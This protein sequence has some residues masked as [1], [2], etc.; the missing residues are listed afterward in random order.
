MERYSRQVLFPFIGEEGQKKL[1]QSTVLVVGVGAL[2]TVASNHLAR[3]GVGKIRLVDRDYVELSNL[4]RQTLF[5]EDDVKA[6]LPKAIAAK[7]KLLKLNSKIEVEAIVTD[8]TS[9]NIETLL[10]EVD[11]IIDGTDN[12]KTR[13]IL[14]DAAFKH[15]IPFA[16]AGVVSSRGMTAFFIPGQTPCLRCMMSETD[17]DGQTCDTI[18][19]ISPAV[20]YVVSMQ[21]VETFKYLTGNFN[22]LRSTLSSFDLWLNQH[23]EMKLNDPKEDCP[24]CVKRDYPALTNHENESETMLCGRNTV[25]IHQTDHINLKET[26]SRLNKVVQVKET[27]FLLKVKINEEINFIVFS[28]G[29][30]LIQGTEDFILARNYYD[31]YIGL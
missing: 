16:Y 18:G 8:V 31:K 9:A 26:A 20:D 5:D 12:L 4:Q 14:N 6:T 19:V 23:Y 17:A 3:S 10:S 24:T 15:H 1:S 25:Q 28:D 13:F 2:G 30:V 22:H 27:P 29:R 21:I 7:N 11:V